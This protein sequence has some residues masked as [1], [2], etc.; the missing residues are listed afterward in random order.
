MMAEQITELKL[1]DKYDVSDIK[2][3]DPAIKPYINIQPR[4]LLKSYGRN[5]EKF[6]VLVQKIVASS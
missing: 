5:L 4:I 1:M 6:E 2:I 3:E